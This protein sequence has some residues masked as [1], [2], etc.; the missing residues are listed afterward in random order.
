MDDRPR[1]VISVAA[2]VVVAAVA[3]VAFAVYRSIEDERKER[4]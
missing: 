1:Y 4:P 2:D 3:D